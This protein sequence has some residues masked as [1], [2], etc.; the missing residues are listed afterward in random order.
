M[1][2][3]FVT[4]IHDISGFFLL[5]S[6]FFFNLLCIIYIFRLLLVYYIFELNYSRT[7]FNENTSKSE[8]KMGFASRQFG[9]TLFPHIVSALE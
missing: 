2:A 7:N 8:R 9:G 4:S 1:Y 6:S 5:L 3:I